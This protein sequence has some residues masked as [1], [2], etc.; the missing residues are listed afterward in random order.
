M[1][2][3]RFSAFLT[4]L[5]PVAGWIYV[6]IYQR[7][8]S[9]AL[10]HLRQ[11]IGL[12]LFMA[13]AVAVWAAVGWVLAW[14]PFGFIFTIALFAGVVMALII[15]VYAW[16]IGAANALQGRAVLLPIFGRLAYRMPIL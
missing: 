14:L 15:G 3:R 7:K 8:N 5:L 16:I 1:I 2:L 10:F 11:S 9:L 13:A 6:I 12:S 4:Y